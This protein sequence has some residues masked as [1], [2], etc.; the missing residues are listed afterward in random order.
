MKRFLRAAWWLLLIGGVIG[1]FYVRPKYRPRRVESGVVVRGG[2][3]QYV[4]EEAKTQLHVVR[5]VSAPIAGTA[6]RI[7]LEVGDAVQKGQLITTIEDTELREA[8]GK[9]RARIKEIQGRLEGID[10]ALPKQSEIEAAQKRAENAAQLARAAQ[11]RQQA[12]QEVCH[13]LEAQFER[14]RRLYEDGVTSQEAYDT[15]RHEFTLAQ[16][17]LAWRAADAQAAALQERIAELEKQVLVDSLGDVEHLNKVYG[18]QIEQIEAELKILEH[19]IGKT[20]VLSPLEG[21]VLEKYLDSTGPVA[22]GTPLLKVGRMDSIEI[23]ADILSDEI[24]LV[25]EGQRVIIEGEALNGGNATGVVKR[26]YPSGFTKVSALGVRQQRVPVLIDF[27]NSRLGL[28]PGVEV[29]VKIVVA[30]REG[31]PLVPAA[32]VFSTASGMAAFRIVEGRA[33][34]TPVNIGLTGEDALEVLDG[35]KVGEVVII[36]PPRDIRD[37]DRVATT[38]Q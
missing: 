30:S 8:L 6:Q 33:A 3:E 29:D 28:R 37:G 1:F 15:A 24:G 25:A 13:Y 10:V 7:T 31:V 12:A 16:K 22:E 9:E 26:I 36:R 21:V 20:K 27:D 17:E 32:A 4:V 18:A 35:L 23:R 11:A 14:A 2:I 19:R 38:V 34:L 5:T